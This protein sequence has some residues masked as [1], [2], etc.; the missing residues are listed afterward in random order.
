MPRPMPGA[1]TTLPTGTVTFLFTDIEGSTRLLNELGNSYPKILARHHEI[2]RQQ[3]EAADGYEVSTDGDAFFAVFTTAVAALRAAVGAQQALAAETWPDEVALRVRM[4]IH[5][6]TGE[7]LGPTYVGIDVHRAARIAAAGHG[8]QLLI[9]ES[10][11]LLLGADLPADVSLRDM[12]EH[13]LKDLPASEHLFQAIVGGLASD[14]PAL[15]TQDTQPGNLPE[16]TTSFL[17]RESDVAAVAKLLEKGRLITLTG[18]GGT[19]KTRLSIEVARGSAA[20]YPGGAWFVP[21]EAVRDPQLVL[22]EIATTLRVTAGSGTSIEDAIAGHIGQ[23]PTLLVLDNLE[24]IVGAGSSIARLIAA[25]AG[26]KVIASSR[27][28]LRVTNEQEYPVPPLSAE[29]A[30]QLFIERARQ[31]Q[32]AFDP[33]RPALEAI[34]EIGRRLDGLPL[35]IELAAAR[36]RVLTPEQILER[37][38]N[39]L[40]L[41]ST[42]ATDL[43]DRQRTLRGAIDWSYDLLTAAEKRFFDRLAVF[44]GAPDLNAIESV[45]DPDLELGMDPLDAVE[46]LVEKSLLRRSETAGAAR[47]G[48]LE[49]IRE[50]ARERL[51]AGGDDAELRARHAQYYVAL[52]ERFAPQLLGPEGDTYLGLLAADHDEVRATIAWS[53]EVGQPEIGLRLSAAIWRFWHLRSHLTEGRL[54]LTSL[55][56]HPA[57]S[58]ES[59]ARADGLTA[60]GGVTY[61][62]ND[63]EATRAAYDEALETNRH[64][65]EPGAIAGSL[66]DVSFP[67]IIAGDIAGARETLQEALSLYQSM[68]AEQ[69]VALVREAMAV[70]AARGGDMVSARAIE[71]EI[72]RGY[73]ATGQAFKLADGLALL[74]AIA[75]NLGDLEGARRSIAESASIARE[76]GAMEAWA[77]NLGIAAVIALREDRLD[78]AATLVGAIAAIEERLGPL[79]KPALALGL[80]DPETELRERME[81][82]ELAQALTIGRDMALDQVMKNVEDLA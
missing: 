45:V 2:V 34:A 54:H 63:L 9:S 42:G 62:Q 44:A 47:F 24:Q 80:G 65:G 35:A 7:L 15:R 49:T 19:G 68:G 55:L 69:K 28:P 73:R 43:T 53:L 13:R 70:A 22:P 57:A 14:F 21:L 12:G 67:M 82:T 48:Y 8:G 33:S 39:R 58:G 61:W 71:G 37:L 79:L 25:A 78:D 76:T 18:A 6:G 77:S 29:P 56:A 17:G 64:L 46:R 31:I 32:P 16:P 36:I 4:G 59:R 10:A 60:L 5:S 51:A 27:E 40:R 74:S 3:I 81:A 30:A 1:R 50:F 23:R 72:I 20:E 11:R 75:L 26:L 66:Y 52:A 38:G 41:L